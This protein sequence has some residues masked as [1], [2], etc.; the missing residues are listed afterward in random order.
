MAVELQSEKSTAL[1]N[2]GLAYYE[3]GMYDEAL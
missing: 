1:D 2:L 3:G